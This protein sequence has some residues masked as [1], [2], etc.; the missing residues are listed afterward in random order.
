MRPVPPFTL[1][2]ATTGTGL[3]SLMVGWIG[4][5]SIIPSMIPNDCRNC[6]SPSSLT[7]S[8]NR[9]L[10]CS[11]PS[12][13]SESGACLR[14][15]GNSDSSQFVISAGSWFLSASMTN[16]N[17]PTLALIRLAGFVLSSDGMAA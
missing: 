12:S 16:P 6:G 9:E 7:I 17:Q 10:L 1:N 13:S 8:I 11:G 14:R 2:A 15:V 4:R 5:N 3:V